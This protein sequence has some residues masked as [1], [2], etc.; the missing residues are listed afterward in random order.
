MQDGDDGEGESDEDEDDIPDT[1]DAK[2][3]EKVVLFSYIL[4]SF[5]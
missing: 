3:S 5:L 4:L 2:K 1:G